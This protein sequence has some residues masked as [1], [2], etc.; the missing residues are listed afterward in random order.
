MAQTYTRQSSLA[1]GDTITAAL[2]N[3]EY[4][5]LLNAFAYSSSSA[6]ST[7]HRHDGTAAQ[8]GNIHTIGDLDFLNKILVTG[9][10][11]EFY[12]EVSSAA[13]KQMV[14][15]DGAL[16]PNADS[17]LDLGTSSVYFKDAFIDSITTTGN[18]AVGGNLTVTGTTTFNGGTLTLGDSAADNVVFGADVDSNIIPDDDDSYDLGTSSQQWRNL[19]ID[20]TANIDSLVADTADINGGTVDGTVIGGSSAAA[21][22]GT[23]ITG[24][25]F[26]IGSADI[27]EAELETIDGVTAG[28]VAASKAIVV[29]S[30]KDFT[31]ARNITLTGELDAG[32]LDVSGDV[33]IDGTLE[34]DALS[35]NGTAVT[36]SATD[37]NLI[38]GITNGTVIASKA[39]VTDSNKDITGGRNITISGEL[40]A[41][42]LDISGDA[43]IDGTLEADAITIA[44][45]TLAE[46]ISDTVGAMVSSNTE[47]NITVTYQDADNTL[48]FA[49]SGSADTTGNAATATALETARTIHGVSF[50]GTANIDLSEV[51]QDTVGAMFSSN[52]ETNITA[53]YQDLDGTVDLVIGTL[54]QDTTGLAGTATALATARTIGGTSFDGSANIAVA[55]A[56]TSTALATARTIHGV[57]FDGT[58]NIDLSEVVQDTVG[59]MF[60]SNTES[61]ITVAYEDGDGTIDLTVGTL[62]QN[63]TGSA[64]TLTTA[65]TIGGTSFDGSA[66]IAVA[67]ST[68]ATT[69]ATART[70]GGVSFDGSANIV[71]T[72]FAA[73]TFSGDLNVDSGVLFADVSANRVGI[74][75]ASPDVSL[76]LGANTDAVH[77][78][79]GNTSQRPGS[80]AAGYFRYNSETG[81]F[82]GYTDAWGAIAGS[83]GTAPAVNTMTGDGSDTTLT[84]TSAPVN[85]NATVVTLDG[86]VQHK[87]TYAVS[88]NT[89][90]FSTAPPNGVAVE[91]ITW[92]NTA[93]NA[94]L[95]MQDADG[96]TQVQVE[97]SSDEDKIRFDTGG[98][99]RA[100]LD[101][102]GLTLTTGTDI[103]TA[104]AG[105][106]NFRAGVN[107]GNSIASGGNYNVVLGDEAGTAITTG[108]YNTFVGY[109]AG[110]ATTEAV[111]NIAIGGAALSTNILGSKSVA[112]GTSALFV[113]NPASA[114]N[115]FNT[116]VGHEAGAA[117]TTGTFNTLIGGLAGDGA[118]TASYSTA[119]GYGSLGGAMTG[120]GNVAL[121]V[122]TLLLATSAHSNTAVG[123]SAM[124]SA[125]T[126]TNNVA[127]GRNALD[128]NTTANANTAV[129]Y[130][131]LGANT[132]GT[133]NVALGYEAMLTNTTA[134]NNTAVGL[135]AL[136]LNTTGAE[137]TVV[138][139]LA[140]DALTT[141]SYNV[142]I[143]MQALGA[144][145]LGRK[146]VAIGQQ[147]LL[148]QNFTSATDTFNTAVGFD[149]G[150]AITTG[151]TNTI[152]GGLAGD[153]LT[154]GAANTAVGYSALSTAGIAAD[155]N[156][157]IGYAAGYSVTTGDNNL[158]LGSDAGRSGSPGGAISTG[159]NAIVLG[160]ENI[161]NAHIQ[162]DWTVASDQRDKTDFTA[163]DLGLDFV[164]ALA[165][166]T[167]KW[168]KRAK[169]GDK[170]ADDYDIT[171]YTPDG[172]HKEDWLD[173]G[174]KAQEVEALEIA[175]GYNKSSKTNLVSSHSGDGKQMGLQYSKFIPILVKAIQEQNA[176][177]ES[178][179]A[180]ITTLEG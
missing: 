164:K 28:T 142:A 159:S 33:D 119:L 96:D 84:L 138:G 143:G 49:F 137:N 91:C 42:T 18:V 120:E 124:S 50:D 156:T 88:G 125:T 154:T 104:S 158:L 110:D 171:N 169:Y 146:S 178:L 180:R 179:T 22:T 167:Y 30:N 97:E 105:T 37:I 139:S 144:D 176:L 76:D 152:V 56:A 133:S 73:A 61:G 40:D 98:I 43:D 63:T 75:Q 145:T 27:S 54:N 79:T 150:A 141:G 83:G 10:T 55:L 134:N 80:P 59:A 89:L 136:K 128:A 26:V 173:I 121:G 1:D 51:V 15:Q 41:A 34:T 94:A 38:D 72:T 122:N 93:I 52:T 166:V 127:V 111:Y 86:V 107:A 85:E 77:V 170:T 23:A 7:G 100:V 66:N 62:N 99:E 117:V 95:L 4:N 92:T 140:A 64:A 78:P 82:E 155:H 131:S 116:A 108:D 163:L 9:N 106:S 21:I 20:G 29:D 165:P 172:T 115:M 168:D 2:F 151:T 160:D 36:A 8:G 67:L 74:N 58:A 109:A 147:A 103:I 3:N 14:L 153:A 45:V 12:V 102:S 135:R 16:V 35:L 57:S 87:G 123:T 11:W 19:F 174:F 69:L 31:G 81:D 60:S 161:G 71:P 13:A 32:S 53:T 6:S 149:A 68:D 90:T 39:I 126:G 5:Q 112:V 132:T 157:A 48:D 65:R 162:V 113:Q 17:D 25:S 114:V 118:T 70:I 177:I 46:T 148:V 44:G 129:G 130:A 24:T 101:S 175:A 47:T